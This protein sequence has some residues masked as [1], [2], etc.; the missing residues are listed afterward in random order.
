MYRRS[1]YPFPEAKIAGEITASIGGN[2]LGYRIGAKAFGTGAMRG[3][4]ATPGP[5]WARIGGAMVG[6]FTSVMA[7]NYGYETSL[8]IMNQAGVFGEKGINRPNQSEKIMNAMNA[9]EFD[10][11]ITLGTAS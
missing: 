4:R 1:P 7:A 11:K 10:A 9:G 5:F 2:I 3:L 6:G 8:D